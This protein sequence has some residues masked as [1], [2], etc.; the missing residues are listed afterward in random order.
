MVY[1]K[2]SARVTSRA[3]VRARLHLTDAV[4]TEVKQPVTFRF[5][6][7][8]SQIDMR[9]SIIAFIGLV[10]LLVPAAAL[11]NGLAL[12]PTMGWLHWER[13]MCNTDCDADPQNCI[14]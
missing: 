14:R 11:D 1:F 12:I 2:G 5:T 3:D 9:A 8:S 4:N 6:H 7:S 10:C 13:F